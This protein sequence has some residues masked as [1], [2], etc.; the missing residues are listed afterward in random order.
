[1]ESKA[2]KTEE[3]S[4]HKSTENV[5]PRNSETHK[6]YD[7]HEKVAFKQLQGND[8]VNV[9]SEYDILKEDKAP[10]SAFT[11]NI[12]DTSNF[13]IADGTYAA[14]CSSNTLRMVVPT[15][16][17]DHVRMKK[18]D[19]GKYDH[20]ELQDQRNRVIDIDTYDQCNV[21]A[22]DKT[23]YDTCQDKFNLHQQ[24]E[25]NVY[26]TANFHPT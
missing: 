7:E 11:G 2:T 9:S 18:T 5:V 21:L 10:V 13:N 15:E 16:S 14:S 19:D 24:L 6:M 3:A 23:Y 22:L 1:L 26:H 17:Y 25:G 4:Q 8:Q 12:Y 20:V